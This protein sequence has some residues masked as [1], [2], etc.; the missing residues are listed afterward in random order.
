MDIPFSPKILQE[1]GITFLLICA[2]YTLYK[3]VMEVQDLR[4]KDS[5][6]REK[7]ITIALDTAVQEIGAVN[8]TMQSIRISLEKRDE[9]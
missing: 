2:V 9:H 7:T 4:V 1:G 3:K 6:E 8:E 5:A